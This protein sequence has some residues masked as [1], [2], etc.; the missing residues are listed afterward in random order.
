M[1]VSKKKLDSLKS[2]ARNAGRRF[3]GGAKGSA[4]DA[5]VGAVSYFAHKFVS[6]KS[7]TVSEKWYVGPAIMA[8]GGHML[9]K[10]ART[11]AAGS[12]LLGAAGYAGGMGYDMHKASQKTET[13]GVVQ[14][15]DVGA[16]V[17]PV[18]PYSLPD[19]DGTAS[20]YGTSSYNDSAW[21]GDEDDGYDDVS[22]AMAL[23]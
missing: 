11:S 18:E 15:A 19:S 16:I 4:M 14:P 6:A 9:K 13:K 12:A 8:L 10:K 17:S 5:G 23:Q 22:S 7:T 2:R 1:K 20:N 21:V 3:A